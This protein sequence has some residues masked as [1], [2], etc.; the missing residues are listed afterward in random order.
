MTYNKFATLR[1]TRGLYTS[2][3]LL[4]GSLD[5][6]SAYMLLNDL[7]PLAMKK[8][9]NY[10]EYLALYPEFTVVFIGKPSACSYSVWGLGLAG[11]CWAC[12][13][14][15]SEFQF[16]T[17]ISTKAP[18]SQALPS[19]QCLRVLKGIAALSGMGL[20]LVWWGW[21][22]PHHSFFSAPAMTKAVSLCPHLSPS[23]HSVSPP[24]S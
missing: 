11:V 21:E 14:G 15:Q 6:G 23:C 1:N 9:S 2:P 4:A 8:F 19:Y 24:H 20:R 16:V 5:T 7:E 22:P 3:S 10:S 18:H 17:A 13:V 12:E